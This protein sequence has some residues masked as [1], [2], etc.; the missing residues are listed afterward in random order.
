MVASRLD[1][2]E[3]IKPPVFSTPAE[4]RRHRKERLAASFR[5][6]SR[7]GF[8]EGVAGHI[9]ARDPELADHFWVNPFGRHFGEI[10]VSDLILVNHRGET[11][12][13]KGVANRAALAIH[14]QIHAG[15]PD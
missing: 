14:S 2:V 8:D 9:T 6:F 4:E 3:S 5:L 15:R 11:V 10:C 12:E 7:F 13:G 1:L